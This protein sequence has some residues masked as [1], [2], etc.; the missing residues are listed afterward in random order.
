M[1]SMLTMVNYYGVYLKFGKRVDLKYSHH[2]HTELCKV[3]NMLINLFV[4]IISQCVCILNHHS[5]HYKNH[6]V[7][8]KDIQF[9]LADH[10]SVKLEK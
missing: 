1:S 5:I 9:L 2:V 3:M 7:Q 8:S 6:N 4:V 10:T